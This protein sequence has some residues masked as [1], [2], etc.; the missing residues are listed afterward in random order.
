[1]KLNT[2]IL[3][4]LFV[5]AA[6]AAG[7]IT[8]ASM[9]SR[10]APVAP[11]KQ[12][13]IAHE[14][15]QA[16]STASS[17]FGNA[18]TST[19]PTAPTRWDVTRIA[20]VHTAFTPPNGYWVYFYQ[21]NLE[22][23]LVNGKTPKPGSQNP[24]ASALAHRVAIIHPVEWAHDNFPTYERFITTMAQFD[25]VQGTAA[26]NLVSCLDVHRNAQTGKTT[27]GLPYEFFSLEAI[28][29]ADKSAQGLRSFIAVRLGVDNDRAILISLTDQTASAVALKLAKSMRIASDQ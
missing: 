15:T 22:Y 27:A 19:T 29:K 7:V 28:R 2:R 20:S 6:I 17:T 24:V 18:P 12:T 9:R 3:I 1:M 4:G 11:V 21:N 25:C 8:L 14:V 16:L 10:Q 26:D 23:W 5:T 13:P